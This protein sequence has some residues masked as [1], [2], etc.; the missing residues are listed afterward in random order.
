MSRIPYNQAQDCITRGLNAS[1][2][3]I[4]SA[5]SLPSQNPQ[6]LILEKGTI[7]PYLLLTEEE[8]PGSSGF[9]L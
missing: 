8:L 6:E 1:F 4:L 3:A 2:P 5:P 7:D 9:P